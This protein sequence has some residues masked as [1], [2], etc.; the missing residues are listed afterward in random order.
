VLVTY[1][2]LLAVTGISSYGEIPVPARFSPQDEAYAFILRGRNVEPGSYF[3]TAFT[4][5]TNT[6]ASFVSK[7][8]PL[9]QVGPWPFDL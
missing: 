4:P 7:F 2:N 6:N 5:P 8:S 1:N 3:T 9:P